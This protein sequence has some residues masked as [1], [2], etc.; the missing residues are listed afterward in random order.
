MSVSD[1]IKISFPAIPENESFARTAVA[2]F[3]AKAD[4]AVDELADIRTAVS[5]AVTNAVVHA[6]RGKDDGMIFLTVR[7]T[8]ER[9]VIIHIRDKGC[10]IEDIEKAMTPLFTTAQNDER[11]G[12]GFSVME[13]FMDRITVKSSVQKGTCV[14]L[15]KKLS[16]VSK[17]DAV[18]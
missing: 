1:H 2:A 3:I 12:L 14:C 16:A 13:S 18:C 8:E 11:S 17:T 15:V 4:P 5:E 9:E 10:G 7:L 6:Y